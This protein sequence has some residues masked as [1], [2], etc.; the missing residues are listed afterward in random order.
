MIVPM[1]KAK[2]VFL[3]E[4]EEAV[5]K[6]LQRVGEIMVIPS[7]ETHETLDSAKEEAF[8]QRSQ[9][10]LQV[11]KPFVPKKKLTDPDAFPVVDYQDF[12][13]PDYDNSATLEK[14]EKADETI[15]RL[16]GENDASKEFI[17][18]LQPWADLD[19][20]LSTIYKTKYTVVHTGYIAEKQIESFM[21]QMKALDSNSDIKLYG[22]AGDTQAILIVNW[23][24][25]DNSIMD[26]TKSSGFMEI[27]LPNE[28]K[29]VKELVDEKEKM[30]EA[31]LQKI[32]TIEGQLS[33][34][35][36]K[37]KEI[38]IFSD[39]METECAMK[40]TQVQTTVETVYLEGW[41]RFDRTTRVENAIKAVTGDYDIE[42]ADPTEDETPP[43]ALQNNKIS[44]DFEPLTDMYSR[45]N[46]K[47]LDPNTVMSFWY[48]IIFGM[49]MADVG[50]GLVLG[51]ASFVM[52]KVM[53]PKGTLQKLLKIFFYCSITTIIW[54]V[55]FGS[56][57]GEA[58]FPPLWFNPQTYPIVMLILTL[59]L[60]VIHLCCG[61]MM[62]FIMNVK[63]GHVFDGIFDNISWILI[64]IGLSLTLSQFCANMLPVEYTGGPVTIPQ[65]VQYIGYGVL[66]FGAL[67]VLFTAGR[68]KKGIGKV[69]G[70]LGGL[71]GITS[72]LSDILSYARI[73]ALAMSGA[74]IAYVMNL[75]AGMVS[76][77]IPV[78][79]WI[80]AIVI[81]IGGHIFNLA[82]SLLSAYV[83]D[84]RL[85]YIEF[86]GKFFEGGGVDFKP[87]TLQYK[88]IYEIND[89]K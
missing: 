51:I 16:K 17:K 20:K 31:N 80:F 74:I 8:V 67:I 87:L 42:F 22:V 41:V 73:L 26:Q 28:D 12:I 30:I 76:G 11:L 89:K 24:E 18:S 29:S 48:W 52:L 69:I 60:G 55:I 65:I 49:M 38:K 25:D 15:A 4:D 79:G 5:L 75:L 45:P 10:S 32:A 84:C 85:Q 13:N 19:G 82:M 86:Y 70:G 7:E 39:Q 61:M 47:E 36:A 83:H 3:K 78:I 59:V 34:L 2:I 64:L 40:K 35:A 88:Y 37:E 66:G 62:K 14:I 33:N 57:F 50:Y 23:H 27:S 68:A 81:Y 43:T 6:Q 63:S 1:K 9:K 58:F 54:G 46:S 21:E 71:Y 77:S 44:A 53:K 56:Y 72:Y